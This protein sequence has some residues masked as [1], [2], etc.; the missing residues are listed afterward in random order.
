MGVISIVDGDYKPTYNWGGTTLWDLIVSIHFIS[1]KL[2]SS[3]VWIH[4]SGFYSF[5]VLRIERLASGN[6]MLLNIGLLKIAR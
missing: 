1:L 2:I 3:L 4:F 5:P 6:S